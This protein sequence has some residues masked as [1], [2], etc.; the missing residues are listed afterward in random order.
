[1]QKITTWSLLAVATL[2]LTVGC[3]SGSGGKGYGSPTTGAET[4]L[5]A[6]P[7]DDSD[8]AEP[9]GANPTR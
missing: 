5:N 4:P 9:A 8:T 2:V 6:A 1:M 3:V 7:A